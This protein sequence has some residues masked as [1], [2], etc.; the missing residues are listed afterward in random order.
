[1]SVIEKAR[2]GGEVVVFI[3]PVHRVHNNENDYA[4]QF[5]GKEGTKTVPTNT[6]RR[7]LNI[8]GALNPLNLK[9]PTVLLAEGSCNKELMQIFLR[10]LR[11]DYPGAEK[12][13]AFMDN[14]GYNRALEVQEL[15]RSLNITLCYLPPY[16]PNLNLIERL[17]KFFKKKIMKN[18]YYPSYGL[19]YQAVTDFFKN[20]EIY[21]QNLASLITL[22]FQII[23]AI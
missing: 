20:F 11:Q 8:I 7:R 2:K 10:Q 19:F 22:N 16:C 18:N 21:E 6:G 3:D 17:W 13:T 12:I 4:W 5:K 14:A 23:K 9:Q 1:M 15:A